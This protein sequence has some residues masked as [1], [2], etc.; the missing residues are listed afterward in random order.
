MEEAWAELDVNEPAELGRE[1]G[2]EPKREPSLFSQEVNVHSPSMSDYQSLQRWRFD[3]RQPVS[4]HIS[5]KG[6]R[7]FTFEFLK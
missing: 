7:S 1:I 3:S 2:Q 6:Q 5:I 4:S